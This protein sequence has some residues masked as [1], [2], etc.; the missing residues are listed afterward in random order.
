M[1]R[2]LMFSNLLILCGCK[3]DSPHPAKFIPPNITS[4][5]NFSIKNLDPDA[6]DSAHNLISDSY[7]LSIN[8]AYY[9][10]ALYNP[11]L[12]KWTGVDSII[13][14]NSGHLFINNTTDSSFLSTRARLYVSPF[15]DTGKIILNHVYVRYSSATGSF[16]ESWINIWRN[17]SSDENDSMVLQSYKYGS[18]FFDEDTLTITDKYYAGDHLVISGTFS[19]SSNSRLNTP[20]NGSTYLKTWY[21]KGSFSN[22]I[23]Q[24]L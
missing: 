2:I 8:N 4:T 9:D 20:Y 14:M 13:F 3:K 15:P 7:S 5:V 12:K 23:W 19:E 18:M 24:Y 16:L 6:Y 17:M 1:R 22:I 21:L 11:T 10:T